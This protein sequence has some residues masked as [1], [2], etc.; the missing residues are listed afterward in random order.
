MAPTTQAPGA[1]GSQLRRGRSATQDTAPDARSPADRGEPQ[2]R[3]RRA[4][5]ALSPA[6][7]VPAARDS[8]SG[9]RANLALAPSDLVPAVPGSSDD[10]T[11][12]LALREH[13]RRRQDFMRAERSLTLQI[14]AIVRRVTGRSPTPE[15][16]ECSAAEWLIIEPN[17]APLMAARDMVTAAKKAEQKR[18]EKLAEEL[19]V[20]ERFTAV[21][22]C[23]AWTLAQ[24]IGEAGDLSIYSTPAKLWK[25]FGVGLVD[26]GRQRRVAGDPELA[27]RHGYAASRRA[28][29][30]AIGATLIKVGGPYRE[31]YDAR[32]AYEIA[33]AA[34]LGLIVAPSAKIPKAKAAEYR[35]IGHIHLRAKRYME[36]R[37]LRELWRGWR[38]AHLRTSTASILHASPSPPAQLPEELRP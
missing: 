13:Y 20:F 33:K 31:V 27:I 38:A 28:V 19:A 14:K 11:R 24:L 15:V 25:R 18:A 17:V 30:W 12:S 2:R 16:E 6:V 32:K 36:K 7:D 23:R 34:E 4:K 29:L 35:S 22:G 21:R 10:R 1:R 9:R 8:I 3:A 5:K 26:G 37:L